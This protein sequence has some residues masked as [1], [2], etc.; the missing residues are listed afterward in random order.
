MSNISFALNST[1]SLQG[2]LSDFSSS[3][4]FCVISNVYN[5]KEGGKKACICVVQNTLKL[6]HFWVLKA[7]LQAMQDRYAILV[8]QM[9]KLKSQGVSDLL[10]VPVLHGKLREAI[11]PPYFRPKV[12]L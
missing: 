11:K 4:S 3:L 10:N 7:T 6:L 9:E 5:L 12:F 2:Y 1:F 8:G